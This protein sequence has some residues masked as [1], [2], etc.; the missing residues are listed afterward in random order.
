MQGV[1]AENVLLN[2]TAKLLQLTVYHNFSAFFSSEMNCNG[3]I[4]NFY[5]TAVFCGSMPNV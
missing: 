2:F 1:T 5:S 3:V 4:V